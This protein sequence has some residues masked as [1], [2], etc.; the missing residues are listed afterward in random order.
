MKTYF[1]GCCEW[2]YGRMSAFAPNKKR[3]RFC[4]PSC[5]AECEAAE[6]LYIRTMRAM[7]LLTTDTLK[8]LCRTA[9]GQEKDK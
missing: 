3:K 9:G 8:A 2:C 7:G 4:S 6:R 5:K 1:G